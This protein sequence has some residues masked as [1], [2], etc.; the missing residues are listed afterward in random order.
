V[1]FSGFGPGYT[2]ATKATPSIRFWAARLEKCKKNAK[3]MRLAGLGSGVYFAL[4][5]LG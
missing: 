3:K 2:A 4:Q 1:P 5:S